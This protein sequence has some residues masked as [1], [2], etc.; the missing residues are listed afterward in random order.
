MWGVAF[1]IGSYVVG[2]GDRLS[3]PV[4]GLVMSLG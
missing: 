4:N 1:D 3:V 2:T